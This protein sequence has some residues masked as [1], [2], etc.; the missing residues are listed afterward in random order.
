VAPYFLIEKSFFFFKLQSTKLTIL[1]GFTDTSLLSAVLW[2]IPDNTRI[3]EISTFLKAQEM[4][5]TS[6]AQYETGDFLVGFVDSCTN[7]RDLK[8]E[9]NQYVVNK[10][11]L[12]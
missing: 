9:R 1:Q 8:P 2:Q 6:I 11:S 5:Q 4:Q 3:S 12:L 10:L 7:Y